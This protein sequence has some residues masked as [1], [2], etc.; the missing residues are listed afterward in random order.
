MIDQIKTT[1]LAD[2]IVL[3]SHNG[4]E[5]DLKLASRVSG[6]DVI[7]GGHTHDALP[8]PIA[9]KYSNGTTWV[10]NAGSHG[11]FL[12]V[13]DMDIIRGRL[14]DLRYR[15]LPVFSNLIE[16]DVEMQQLINTIRAP[17]V[18][19]L[20]QPLGVADRLLYRRDT[21]KGTFDKLIL[22]A[23][24]TINDSQIALSPGFR[25]GA[26]LLPGHLIRYEDVMN[27]TAITYPQTYVRDLSGHEL[28]A[29]LE[30][31]ADNL[32]NPDP[33]YRQGGDMVR[34][35]GIRFSCQPDAPI[36]KRISQMRLINGRLIDADK[37]YKVAGW[38]SAGDNATGKAVDEVVKQYL[39][40]STAG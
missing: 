14:R 32:F 6:L 2:V 15:L 3:L 19:Q 35:G 4:L 31:V 22:D 18:N 16:P 5:V 20:Q 1:K 10:T 17:F 25:W 36:G 33:Y 7:L 26:T 23:L 30:D 9:V 34:A 40:Q 38:A 37:H 27:Q 13:L 28:K 11:K 8:R 29:I 12:A 24:L 21:Y 39:Q